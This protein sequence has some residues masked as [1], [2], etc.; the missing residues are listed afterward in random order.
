[1]GAPVTLPVQIGEQTYRMVFKFGTIRTFENAIGKPLSEAFPQDDGEVKP[2]AMSL[3]TLSALFW[4][5]LQPSHRITR[6]ASDDL[7][8]QA[9]IA[10]VGEWIGEGMRGYFGGGEAEELEGNAAAK[11]AKK[12]K[13]P[14]S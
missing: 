9:G 6:E 14:P 3:D 7:I 5:T 13:P 1:M 2:T 11:T 8:D 4:A 10:Q 12:A